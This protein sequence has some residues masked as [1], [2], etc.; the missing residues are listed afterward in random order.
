MRDLV[1]A[2]GIGAVCGARSMLGPA[3]VAN[4]AAPRHAPAGDPIS[5]AINTPGTGWLTLAL[6]AGEMLADK[7]ASIPART[8]PLPVIGRLATG[9]LSAA[10]CAPRGE[11]TRWAAAGT[12]GA[13]TGTFALFHLRRLAN[14][15][16]HA[17]NVALGLAEDAL[18]VIAG[19][20]L[21]QRR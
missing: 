10:A 21:L 11:R 12:L 15:Q 18:A 5:G 4:A 9:A 2:Y 19:L 14:Q 8:T 7:S 16:L 20:L 17:P 1:L 3:L 6:A 13:L